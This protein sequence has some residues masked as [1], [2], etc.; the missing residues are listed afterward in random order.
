MEDALFMIC[1]KTW[2]KKEKEKVKNA[3]ETTY[4][5][6]IFPYGKEIVSIGCHIS[7]F[8]KKLS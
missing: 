8:R 6:G 5:I 7:F 2:K 1:G 4:G 3:L